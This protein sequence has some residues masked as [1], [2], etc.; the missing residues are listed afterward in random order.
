MKLFY[1]DKDDNNDDFIEMEIANEGGTGEEKELRWFQVQKECSSMQLLISLKEL[2][3]S[4][5][6]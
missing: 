2:C 6:K 4:A 1:C 5:G 3:D